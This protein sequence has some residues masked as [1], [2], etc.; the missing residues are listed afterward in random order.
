MAE[1][2]HRGAGPWLV[3]LVCCGREDGTERFETWEA[4]NAF[5][6]SYTHPDT[7]HDRAAIIEG[8]KRDIEAK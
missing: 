3:R 4:A 8:P 1:Q 2:V 5:R 6:E 7:G